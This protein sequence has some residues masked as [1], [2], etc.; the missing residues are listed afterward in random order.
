[1]VILD[2]L[3][4]KGRRLEPSATFNRSIFASIITFILLS[5]FILSLDT[6]E[7]LVSPFPIGKS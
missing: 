3:L 4:T 5:L 1:M 2:N 7:S 6:C